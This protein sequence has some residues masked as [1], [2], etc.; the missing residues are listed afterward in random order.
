METVRFGRTG[1]EVSL[2]SL[3]TW[4]HG[5]PNKA[6]ERSVGWS[7]Y[8]REQSKQGLLDAFDEGINHWD[9]A[10]VYGGGRSEELI[11]EVLKQVDRS[12]LVLASKVGWDPGPHDHFYHPEWMRSQLQGSL[13]RLGTD[14][15]DLSLIHI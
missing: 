4:S 5:G 2:I 6:G 1:L 14:V 13:V 8:D 3:G 7:G 11:G 12:E 10:D 9:T 15:L